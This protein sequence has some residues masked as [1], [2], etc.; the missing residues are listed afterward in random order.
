MSRCMSGDT[1]IDQVQ[2]MITL[3]SRCTS[4]AVWGCSQTFKGRSRPLAISNHAS[5]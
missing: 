1:G 3:F 2:P 5:I 4:G